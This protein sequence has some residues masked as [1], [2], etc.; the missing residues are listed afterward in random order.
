LLFGLE[1][2][3]ERSS[4]GEEVEDED[5]DCQHQQNVNPPAEGVAADEADNPEDEKDNCD[6]PEH[7]VVS[8][9]R[10]CSALRSGVREQPILL[11]FSVLHAAP[12]CR[13]AGYESEVASLNK[14]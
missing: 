12:N 14:I 5:N 9:V 1:P 13:S 2:P 8:L 11:L 4:A 3:L 6:R 7:V 10:K